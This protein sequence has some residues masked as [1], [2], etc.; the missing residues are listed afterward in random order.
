MVM[1]TSIVLVAAFALAGLLMAAHAQQESIP[2]TTDWRDYLPLQ[3]GNA[4]EHKIGNEI[5]GSFP[6]RYER[7]E[8]VGDTVIEGTSYFVHRLTVYDAAF[9]LLD[10][11]I[12]FLRYDS[13]R[14]TIV[15]LANVDSN[16]EEQP[17]PDP[18]LTCDLSADF[19]SDFTCYYAPDAPPVTVYGYYNEGVIFSLDELE[20][21]ILKLFTHV[22]SGYGIGFIH[23]VGVIAVEA[24][25]EM[26]YRNDVIYVRLD[27][28]EYGRSDV[29]TADEAAAER[30]QSPSIA[31]IHPNPFTTQ[32]TLTFELPSPQH[33]SVALYDVLG[34]RV[35][36]YALGWRSAG[37]HSARI[38]ALALASGAYFVRLSTKAGAAAA[39]QVILRH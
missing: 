3:V 18:V 38:D 24:D 32:V 28:V 13:S 14:A 31:S 29:A 37:T 35:R 5:W 6:E 17:W 21:S 16:L 22:G 11:S 33:V 10:S 20:S 27:G 19:H 26:G 1:N 23:G 4:W 15:A 2:D 30:P 36:K 12:N 8:I 9:E 34:Q 39:S 25:F 7:R